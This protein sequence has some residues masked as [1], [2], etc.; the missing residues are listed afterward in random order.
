[1]KP[2][3]F[4]L[5]LGLSLGLRAQEPTG[6]ISQECYLA[7]GK[8]QLLQAFLYTE[9]EQTSY[10]KTVEDCLY[11]SKTLQ[12]VFDDFIS[13]LLLSMQQ[14]PSLQED[15]SDLTVKLLHLNAAAGFAPSQHN[16]AAIHNSD[17]NSQI[18]IVPQDYPTFMFWT[19]KAASQ[20][21]PRSLFNLAMRYA[22][23]VPEINLIKD[24]AMAYKLLIVIDDMNKEFSGGLESIMPYVEKYKTEI[25]TELG[26]DQA[27]DISEQAKL[28]DI[29]TLD[30]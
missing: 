4:V 1:M 25:E 21:E 29:S 17:P 27:M 5:L 2:L 28:F 9:Q 23:G 18:S 11:E 15:L 6:D 7:L 10:L 19:R 16:F 3:L 13:T 22:F 8:E 12:A 24:S 26:T 14:N 20:G 30:D